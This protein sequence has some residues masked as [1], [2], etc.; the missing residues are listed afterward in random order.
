MLIE[1]K[2]SDKEFYEENL[3]D[4]LPERIIDIHSHVW[5]DKFNSQ[6]PGT[7]KRAV[8]WPKLVARENSIQDLLETYDL[9]FPGKR[10]TPLIFSSVSSITNIDEANNYISEASKKFAVPGLLYSHP[11]WTG[12]ELELKIIKG[13]FL[14]IK[15]YLSLS[16]QYI[17]ADEIRIF[18][19]LPHHLLEV[20]D[21]LGL[22]VMLHIPRRDRFKDPVN[23]HQ[24]LEI[25]EKYKNLKLIVAH[26]GRAY[27]NHDLGDAFDVLKDAD[28]LLYDFSA[29]T[30]EWVFEQLIK[31]VGPKRILFGSD[32]PI[33]R[34]RMKRIEKNGIYVNL[35]PKGLY[36]DVSGDKNMAEVEGNKADDLTFFIYEEINSFLL[37]AKASLLN[38]K[39]IEDIF[40]NNAAKLIKDIAPDKKFRFESAL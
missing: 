12:Q 38:K 32:M 1:I 4:F 28:R 2:Q 20:V 24:I 40:F 37:A 5:L 21:R 22:I 7:D 16:A 29:N 33:V 8:S 25:H 18:D 17:P 9:M 14:G 13:G 26:V 19:F 6:V 39:D 3:K 27:C 30:N 36:G 35:V 31:A 11:H 10:V 34:M 23:Q 15:V